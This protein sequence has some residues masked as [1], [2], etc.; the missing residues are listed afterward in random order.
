MEVRP[1]TLEGQGVRLEPIAPEHAGGLAEQ[2]D[3]TI[4]RYIST[5]APASASNDDVLRYIEKLRSL[6]STVPFAVVLKSTGRAVGSTSYMDIRA[7]HRGLEIGMTWYGRA[8]Q[9]TLVNPECKLL[10]L[11]HAFEVLGCVRVQLK[12]D[13]RNLQSQAGIEKLGAVKEGVLRKHAIMPDGFVRDTVMYSII[14]EEWPS[15]RARLE[16]RLSEV[17]A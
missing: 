12:T 14:A 4:Y 2:Y 16:S 1:V 11:R 3:P 13:A 10:L 17:P 6:P 9:G 15:I 7:E 5:V 8:H